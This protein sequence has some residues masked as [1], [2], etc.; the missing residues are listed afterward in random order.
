MIATGRA[1]AVLAANW[2]PS[3][4]WYGGYLAGALLV[5]P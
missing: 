3:M 5:V 1:A 4:I 2:D